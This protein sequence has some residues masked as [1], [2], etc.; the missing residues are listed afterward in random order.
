MATQ[1]QSTGAESGI[2]QSPELQGTPIFKL[3]VAGEGG[4]GKTSLIRR[5][6]LNNFNSTEIT[7]GSEFAFKE[8]ELAERKLALSIWDFAGENQFR[9]LMPVFCRGAH[10]AILV[11]DLNRFATFKH[12]R[13]WMDIIQSVT[14]DIPVILVG[15]KS[16]LNGG[17]SDEEIKAF[18]QEHKVKAY[19]PV[20]A[21]DG[22]NV[23]EIFIHIGMLMA[24]AAQ[25][26]II[27][28]A[29]SHRT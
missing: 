10:G 12:L 23:S 22:T 7:V 6:I 2:V 25:N 4:A 20:S 15:A 1:Q 16:D 24:N 19:F 21:K 26:G 9:V 17:P 13:L 18:C 29:Y 14:K 8:I 11:F 27:T 5:Y 3:V 28:P